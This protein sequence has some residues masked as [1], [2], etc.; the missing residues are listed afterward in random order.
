LVDYQYNLNTLTASGISVYFISTDPREK[1]EETANK[2]GLAYPVLYGLDGP[3]TAELLGTYYEAERNILQPAAF[4]LN[5]ARAI[6]NVTYS[7]GPAGR[8]YADEA[9][10]V[11]HFAKVQAAKK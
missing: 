11:V 8:L 1:A 4:I 6:A 2:L 7:D 9:L 3:A 10:K 5:P